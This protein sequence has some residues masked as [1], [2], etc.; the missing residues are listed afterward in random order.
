MKRE[1]YTALPQVS[2]SG[3]ICE[4]VD[5]GRTRKVTAQSPAIDVMTDLRQV[6]AAT[7]EPQTP[8]ATANQAMILRGVRSLFVVENDRRMIGL[9]TAT[10]LLGEAPIRLSSQRGL[11]P[12]E[13][14]VRDVMTPAAAV[15]AIDIEDAMRADVGH[16]VATLRQSGRHH[17]LV[18]QQDGVGRFSVRGL[19]SAS[20]IAGQLGIPMPSGEIARTFAEIEA[21]L[22]G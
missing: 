21:A 10:D 7:I 2:I 6:A 1:S 3:A 14:T 12:A 20:Q 8:L 18:V 9:I 13:L 22:A 16:V 11:R 19:F 15:E 5:A 4:V 17:L